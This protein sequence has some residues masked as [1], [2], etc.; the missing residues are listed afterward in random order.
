MEGSGV[1]YHFVAFCWGFVIV[2][3]TLSAY[4]EDEST[5]FGKEF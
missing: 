5:T 3:E 1:C 2:G 4:D